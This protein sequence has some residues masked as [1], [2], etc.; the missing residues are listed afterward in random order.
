LVYVVVTNVPVA[1]DHF[2]GFL[3][4]DSTVAVAVIAST[5]LLPLSVSV[6]GRTLC[7]LVEYSEVVGRR[8]CVYFPPR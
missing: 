8:S 6:L 5:M 3:V 7:V 4:V 1:S 2:V